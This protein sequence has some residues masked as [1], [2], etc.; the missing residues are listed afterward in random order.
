VSRVVFLSLCVCVYV[1]V[2]MRACVV[3]CVGSYVLSA[4]VAEETL[5]SKHDLL[6]SRAFS[7]AA[8]PSSVISTLWCLFLAS[9]LFSSVQANAWRR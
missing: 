1:C 5:F 3:V 9:S 4:G 2:C 8:L 7:F 6:F